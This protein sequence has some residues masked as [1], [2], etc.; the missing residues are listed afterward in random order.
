[1]A[2]CKLGVGD[3]HIYISHLNK[4]FNSSA[5]TECYFIITTLHSYHLFNTSMNLVIPSSHLTLLVLFATQLNNI[6][7][8]KANGT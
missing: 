5:I 4:L 3:V 8:D 2:S 7:H 1:M 6:F